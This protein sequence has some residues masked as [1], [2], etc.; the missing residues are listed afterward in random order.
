MPIPTKPFTLSCPACG[1]HKTYV[2]ASDVLMTRLPEK[3][4]QCQQNELKRKERSVFSLAA[5]LGE[6]C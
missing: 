3:C 1:W 2:P 6:K 5:L 4:P